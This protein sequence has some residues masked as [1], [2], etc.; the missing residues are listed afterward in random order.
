MSDNQSFLRERKKLLK[1]LFN[2]YLRFTGET[3]TDKKR[4][5]FLVNRSPCV[6]LDGRQHV[7]FFENKFYFLT[8][9]MEGE[10][11]PLDDKYADK[12]RF[13]LEMAGIKY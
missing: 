10:C 2:D 6:N 5:Q 4:R 1:N 13:M 7:H 3:L 11:R 8:N 9:S 12:F